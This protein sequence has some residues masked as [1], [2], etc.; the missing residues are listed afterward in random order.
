MNYEVPEIIFVELYDSD[1][2]TES[3]DID[4]SGDFWGPLT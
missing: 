4:D 3:T 2:I 1:I